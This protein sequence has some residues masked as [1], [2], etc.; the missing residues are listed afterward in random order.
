MDRRQREPRSIRI[1]VMS[2]M[3]IRSLRAPKP[4]LEPQPW[5]LRL[6]AF[7][8]RRAVER[9]RRG[10]GPDRRLPDLPP[11]ARDQPHVLDRRVQ[12]IGPRI[13]AAN[14]GRRF[15]DW[16]K[17]VKDMTSEK[18]VVEKGSS[19]DA[20]AQALERRGESRSHDA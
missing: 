13:S 2:E 16:W 1:I 18:R 15:A 19:L 8:D 14:L 4:P 17:T 9:D 11:Q 3:E 12:Q 20:M 5:S 6:W 7:S 10:R